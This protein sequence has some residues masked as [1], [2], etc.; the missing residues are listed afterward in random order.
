MEINK[1]KELIIEDFGVA[2]MFAH[3]FGKKTGNQELEFFENDEDFFETQF[4]TDRERFE[5]IY[6]SDARIFNK[7]DDFVRVEYCDLVSYSYNEA[8]EQ[9][10]AE[11]LDDEEFLEIAEELSEK[12][13][14][15]GLKWM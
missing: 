15:S 12:E 1:I 2:N 13:E 5:A 10:I 6:E 11:L 3:E 9:L 4:K 8:H 7:N 14:M